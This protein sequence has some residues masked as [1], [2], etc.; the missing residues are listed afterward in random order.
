M[1]ILHVIP[2][3]A[4]RDGGPAKAAIETCREL[5]R[6]G[7]DVELYTTNADGGSYCDVPLGRAVRVRGVPV[8]YFPVVA[9]YYYKISPRLASGLKTAVSGFD[10]VHINSLYQFPSTVAAYYC[11]R[12]GVPYVIRPHGTLD[13]FLFRRHR[14]R[15]WLYEILFERRNLRGAA[16]VHFTTMEELQLARSLGLRF[17][18]LVAPLGVDFEEAPDD[19]EDILDSAWP[20]L[21]GKEVVL[22]LS[23]INFKKGLDILARA[24]GRIHRERKQAQLV[25]AGPDNEG[26]CHIY[27]NGAGRS[28]GGATE[29]RAIVRSAVVYGE[30]RDCSSRGDGCG[31][32]GGDLQ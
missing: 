27:R 8:T 31:P 4:A 16:A 10:I 21:F 22:F 5:L 1:R 26:Y 6:C 11:R 15:K 25:I 24:F 13:P 3:L 9:S 18:S 28:K 19:W 23:R 14:P 30:F 7:E 32:T 29:T 2:S 12:Y 20:E 17:R